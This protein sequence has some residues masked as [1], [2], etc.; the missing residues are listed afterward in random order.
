MRLLNLIGTFIKGIKG[1]ANQ[2]KYRVGF[3]VDSKALKSLQNELIQLQKMTSKDFMKI[4][5]GSDLKKAETE[6][7]QIRKTV[8]QVD[9]ALDKAFNSKLGTI[10]LTKFKQQLHGL[11]INKIYSDFSKMGVA[12]Q[13]AFRSLSGQMLT[14]NTRIR[15]SHSLLDKMATTLGN[16]LKW[17][18]A[19]TA[20]NG[21]TRSI[22]QAWGY[23]KSLDG[24]LNDI[25]IV[26]GKSSDEMARFAVQANNAAKQLGK[27]TTDY[28]KASLI[29]A[30]QG[31]S[32]E[33][34]E[35]RAR[36]TLK[37]ANVTG[38]STDA[39]SEEL[40][41]VW[42]GYKVTAEEA[43]LYVDRLA[44]IAAHTASNLEE[45]STGMSKVASAAAAMGV[46]EDQLAAQLSTIIS[47]TRQAPESV[48]TA[49]RTVYARIS[50][51]KAGIDEDGVTLGNYSGKMQALGFSVL[52]AA[53]NLR[54]MG[55]VM[56]EIGNK[57]QFLT[58]EQQVNLAQTMA[59]QRQYS[60]LI[61]LFDNF[62][63]Y[64]RALG[65]AQN[66]AGTLQQQ[67]DIYMESTVAHLN[68]LKASVEDVYDS[69]MNRDSLDSVNDLI[70]AL[71][72]GA[73]IIAR[74]VDSLGGGMN[75]LSS[76][77]ALGVTVFSKQIAGS[78]QTTINNLNRGRQQAQAF[79]DA[80]ANAAV[81]NQ[82]GQG[83]EYTRY[84]NSKQAQLLAIG[85]RLPKEDFDII[86][87]NFNDL[88]VASNTVDTLNQK[89]DSLE[90]NLQ[91]L[92]FIF[93]E[94][95]QE[96]STLDQALASADGIQVIKNDLNNFKNALAP[97][98]ES[99]KELQ[100]QVQKLNNM[101]INFAGWN[102]YKQTI[103][104]A[105]AA[106]H[107]MFTT[108]QQSTFNGKSVLNFFPE[109]TIQSIEKAKAAISSFDWNKMN[110]AQ[111]QAN[112]QAIEQVFTQLK[113]ALYNRIREIRLAMESLNEQSPQNLEKLK[114]ELVA[115]TALVK[116]LQTNIDTLS[117]NA[118]SRIQIQNFVN[119]AGGIAQVGSSIQQLQNLGSIWFNDDISIGQKLLQT[120]T[121]LSFSLPMLISGWWKAG[122]AIGFFNTSMEAAQIAALKGTAGI[123]LAHLSIRRI[124]AGAEKG[125]IAIQL[126]D[127]A[128]L[129]T[130][131]G[132][133]VIGVTAAAAAVLILVKAFQAYNKHKIEADKKIIEEQNQ[134]QQEINKN[135]E[136][137]DSIEKLN[138][139]YKNNEITRSELRSGIQDLIDQYGVESKQVQNLI[140]DYENLTD[141]LKTLREQQAQEAIAS[142]LK[143]QSKEEDIILRTARQGQGHGVIG[144]NYNITF[145]NDASVDL[146][147]RLKDADIYG[148]VTQNSSVDPVSLTM[149][150]DIDNIIELYDEL[151]EVRSE[152]VKSGQTETDEYKEID[153][154]ISKLTE[155]I[156]KYRATIQDISENATFLQGIAKDFNNIENLGQ[157]H[158]QRQ[159]F[160]EAVRNNQNI[161]GDDTD[162][163]RLV[164]TYLQKYYSDLFDQYDEADKR[165]NEYKEKF[166]EIPQ[167]IQDSL[168]N[169][170]DQQLLKALSLS[171]E[172]LTDWDQLRNIIRD[173]DSYELSN[174][175][176]LE[177]FE[178]RYKDNVDNLRKYQDISDTVSS[179]KQ[180]KEDDFTTLTPELQ[181]FFSYAGDGMYKMVGD[182]KE[183]YNAIN[184]AK[185]KDLVQTAAA[186]NNEIEKNK[187]LAEKNFN[188]E[189]LTQDAYSAPN[190]LQGRLVGSFDKDLINQQ[191]DYLDTVIP[192][193]D[194]FQSTIDSWQ[195]MNEKGEITKE[196]TEQIRAKIEEIGDQTTDLEQK[197]E[198]AK[199][200]YENLSELLNDA[201][202]PLDE[203]VDEKVLS[204]LAQIYEEQADQIEGI[205]D[206]MKGNKEWAEDAAQAVLRFDDAIQD[207]ID[208]YENW[209]KILNGGNLAEIA[210]IMDELTDAYA[211]L[212]DFKGQN[213]FSDD[214]LRSTDNLNLMKA[215]IDGDV[216][217]YNQ[218]ME[219]AQQDIIANIT[220][221]DDSFW[222]NK[223][224]IEESLASLEA[225]GMSDIEI[226]AR[227]NSDQ[228]IGALNSMIA[229]TNA[230][231]PEINDLIQSMG[232]SATVREVPP[233]TKTELTS[234]Q[235]WVPP[236]YTTTTIPTGGELMA[237]TY[238]ALTI[239]PGGEGHWETV[240]GKT[241]TVIPGTG[242]IEVSNVH[243]TAGGDIK[244]AQA[245]SGGGTSRPSTG[246]G[247]SGGGGGGGGG[248]KPDTSKKDKKKPFKT[249]KDPYHNINIQLQ[250]I[251]RQLDRVQDK[252]ERLYGK[253]L[254]DNLNKQNQLL[255]QQKNK[256]KQKSE[257]QKKDLEDQRKALTQMGAIFDEQGNLTNYSELISQRQAE[258]QAMHDK[259]N[260]GIQDY[261]NSTDADYK[262]ALGQS[263][264]QYDKQIKE[265]EDSLNELTSAISK[266][267][268]TR[269]QLQDSLDEIDEATQKQIEINIKK[270]NMQLE[271]RLDM[272]KAERDWNKFK[273]NVLEKTDVLKDSNFDKIFKDAKQDFEDLFSYFEVRGSIGSIQMLTNQLNA[274]REQI[275]QIDATGT[276]AIYGDNKAQAME[277]LQNNLKELMEQLENVEE[278]IDKIDQAYLDTIDDIQEGFDEQIENYEYVQD[279]L[280]SDLE[281]LQLLYGDKNYDAMNSY[282]EQLHTNNIN[283]L[284]SLKRQKDFW[285][286][287]WDQAVARGDTNAAK[288]FEQNYKT[289][290]SNINQLIMDSIENLQDKYT[291]ATEKI[292]HEAQLQLTNGKG[293]DYLQ[294]E[295]DLINKNADSY[296]DTINAAFETQKVQRKYQNAVNDAKSIKNQQALKKLMDQQ[297]NILKNKDKLTQ[298]DID[299]AQ[300]LLEVE[301][302]RIALEDA[303]SAKTSMRLKRDSQGNYSYE[304]YADEEGIGEAE[305]NYALAQQDLLNL[306]KDRYNQTLQQSIAMT[307]Q[308]YQKLAELA[309]DQELSEEAKLEKR[310]LLEQQYSEYI[311]FMAQQVSNVRVN[312]MDSVFQDFAYL[313]DTDIE[314]YKNMADSEKDILMN[315]I[316]PTWTSGA[317]MMVD[318]ITGENGL[319]TVTK[320]AFSELDVAVDEYKKELDNLAEAA[321]L[322]LNDIK[323]GIDSNVTSF[324]DLIQKNDELINRMTKELE[325]ITQVKNAVTALIQ[326]YNNATEAAK[327]T[328]TQ[329]Q[330]FIQAQQ[331]QAADYIA[332]QE[333]MADAYIDAQYRM[334]EGFCGA[335]AQMVAAV[336]AANSS[337][338]SGSNGSGSGPSSSGSDYNNNNNNNSNNEE[339]KSTAER[340]SDYWKKHAASGATGMYT[341]DWHSDEGKIAILH[342][343]ELVLN[344]E[345]T[346]NILSAVNIIRAL[347]DNVLGKAYNI[348]SGLSLNKN[349]QDNQQTLEQNVHITASFPNVDN[350]KQ[351]KEAFSELTNLAAQRIMRR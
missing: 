48:G 351:I 337:N 298:Y 332:N 3:D 102:T 338:G 308:Y 207:V 300:K 198:K 285:K 340:I 84:L 306:D 186:L 177:D 111:A 11:N 296:L 200:Q 148:T 153:A 325:A 140:G 166:G 93:N 210:G 44:A 127:K 180:I 83:N 28:T 155:D 269:E 288:K 5:P 291:K 195:K 176:N 55:E 118:T 225:S 97:S 282:Y 36:I 255:E 31:L 82:S 126:F 163:N 301:Q 54:D 271:I 178:T 317:N 160:F 129:L 139:Q 250:K 162:R 347:N 206:A 214:F 189:N 201:M 137:Y 124:T 68:Q 254:I 6:L 339:F 181:K 45:L 107:Q 344:K 115:T 228:F 125:A 263:L 92:G 154:W 106:M 319:L 172:F 218:L 341:G 175:A 335:L 42:N 52:D 215:A 145:A 256:L 121:N 24:S 266:Y 152:L 71:S 222:T 144:A 51:I 174:V 208:N 117:A 316:V 169:L 333:D 327:D 244:Y 304:Y 62:S 199:Q 281:L 158:E 312:L 13:A 134:I 330:N 1:M 276:S 194:V 167:D 196:I 67:Q 157:Y 21:M 230:T 95:I 40:T 75:I 50:D 257:I 223:A 98:V 101:K 224:A 110:H 72:S 33:E 185:V 235:Y 156:N 57:W 311:L 112:A 170:D 4:N 280:K 349:P 94:D 85:N 299:R 184:S 342:E 318:T 233:K 203:D 278:L 239:A 65:I 128:F 209:L 211:D 324:S 20:I 100:R 238:Q 305:Q 247:G 343:K 242:A 237:G 277:D 8:K 259:Y 267:D 294:E 313:Y 320:K 289:S 135:Q 212:L 80:L 25:R 38:Q 258:I 29:Y 234:N 248:S 219:I 60:N 2:I 131:V 81:L 303:R 161:R 302:A 138:N 15:E 88:R 191:L 213:P 272:G 273:R 232:L 216:N 182:A 150:Y 136:L 37:A 179:G 64:N 253:Q 96:F 149:A 19:S 132:A 246:G 113:T 133:F 252:Q 334:A 18:I 32:D 46:G 79:K 116:Q 17:N 192:D 346:A 309:A 284:D 260:E 142:N 10:N 231:I 236:V 103:R 226:D 202:F 34:I 87:K 147:R 261:N 251:N 104:S 77:G 35:A 146:G 287:Q 307:Q 328:V 69:F 114:E 105:N 143:E 323:L 86:Q 322:D 41:A 78:I 23:V 56:E 59:G 109:S 268:K 74:F 39:V 61:A 49:L 99:F 345:D 159:A 171:P 286:E 123:N 108:L 188:Y 331:D 279:L 264:S 122:T 221:N 348:N 76:L 47:V 290:I 241:T 183:F 321:G 164:D 14:V 91:E 205:N 275:E 30:Q 89:I 274:T 168:K 193:S 12:G 9:D 119:L 310:L 120:I 217:S 197:N 292:F 7:Q 295:W 73:T 130:G 141:T 350:K 90:N 187:Q 329:I 315:Q 227:L 58:R 297:L 63:E 314:N 293:F 270:F 243:Q 27:T 190:W 22:D 26:T 229:A 336:N 204:N 249:Q 262:K 326:Q 283:Q 16:T 240:P 265:K 43:E 173:I 245:P 66:A 220:I 53:G 151:I 70:D 165:L